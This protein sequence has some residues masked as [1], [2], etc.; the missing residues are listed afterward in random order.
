[1]KKKCSKCYDILYI[2]TAPDDAPLQKFTIR[3]SSEDNA[4]EKFR[5]M[6]KDQYGWDDT[7]EIDDVSESKCCRRK[8]K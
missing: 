3:A 4:I 2:D 8:K 6:I 1:V 7:F 5:K